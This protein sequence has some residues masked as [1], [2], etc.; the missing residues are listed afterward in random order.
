MADEFFSFVGASG[1]D[2]S[3]S[4][5]IEDGVTILLVKAFLWELIS[6]LLLLLLWW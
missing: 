6:L 5:V 1:E 4:S 3:S 2:E